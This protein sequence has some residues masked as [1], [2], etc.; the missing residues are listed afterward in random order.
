MLRKSQ[1]SFMYEDKMLKYKSIL[2]LT[3][4]SITSNLISQTLILIIIRA[5]VRTCMHT[6]LL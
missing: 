4:C 3:C 5:T 6:E 2:L 1:L